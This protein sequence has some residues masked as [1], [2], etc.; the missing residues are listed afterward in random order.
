MARFG[1]IRSV[2]LVAS[3]RGT[4]SI[5]ATAIALAG[6]RCLWVRPERGRLVTLLALLR[7]DAV[8]KSFGAFS[9]GYYRLF[10]TAKLLGKR[11]LLFWIGSDVLSAA[12]D[13]RPWAMRIQKLIDCNLSVSGPIQGELLSLGIR[14]RVLPI[15]GDIDR[16]R[17][18]PLPARS[19]VLA[20]LPEPRADFYG[21]RTVAKVAASLRDQEFLIVGGK[22]SLAGPNITTLGRVTDMTAVYARTS[23]LLRLAEHDGLSKMVL[24]ALACGR[25][26]VWNRPFPYCTLAQTPE[27]AELALKRLALRP[28]LQTDA[29][30]F[31]RRE[32]SQARMVDG[33]KG[34]LESLHS[35]TTAGGQD[36]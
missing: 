16:L 19:T 12:A 24:E 4:D 23:V 20:Y 36:P 27:H 5:L 2:G 32:Y 26:V 17:P 28:T 13:G 21:A 6:F 10:R 31:V 14:S 35:V 22:P 34:V 15:V 3:E 33:L 18:L 1:R 8:L 9:A 25:H 11:T 30:R 7:A 29:S